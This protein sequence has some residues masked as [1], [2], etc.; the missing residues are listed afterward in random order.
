MKFIMQH[1]KPGCRITIDSLEKFGGDSVAEVTRNHAAYLEH[2][3]EH[4]R[5]APADVSPRPEGG[6]A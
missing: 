4:L 6:T 3:P 2:V 1:V 5:T